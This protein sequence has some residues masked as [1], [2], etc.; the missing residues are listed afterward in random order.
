[1]VK[2]SNKSIGL[3]GGSFD[4]A[5]K[6]HLEISKIAIRKIKLNKVLWLVT[7]KNPFKKK[8]FYSLQLRLYY[9]K[10][11]AKNEKR[12]FYPTKTF[13]FHISSHQNQF[14]VTFEI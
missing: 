13:F 7:R 4:P 14:L 2:D 10:K 12:Y 3:L 1:M 8:P 11:I 6:G 5:H 9:A